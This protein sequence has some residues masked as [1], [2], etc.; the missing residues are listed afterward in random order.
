MPHA[1]DP[2]KSGPY[3][4][5]YRQL[6]KDYVRTTFFDPYSMRDVQISTPHNGRMFAQQGWVV[7]IAANAKNRMG[8]YTGLKKTALL[9]RDGAVIDADE[10]AAACDSFD[11]APWPEMENIGAGKS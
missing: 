3:P 4:Q 2:A 9:M 11:F 1:I 6:A 8:G 10:G 7:C 5:N